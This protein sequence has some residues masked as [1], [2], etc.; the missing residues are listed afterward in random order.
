[1]CV[2]T[3]PQIFDQ[4]DQIGRVIVLRECTDEESENLVREAVAL[5]PSGAIT[6]V[7]SDTDD[8]GQDN[9]EGESGE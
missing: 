7:G 4:D 6:V 8:P 1:M 5:C 2:L 9:A 3:A